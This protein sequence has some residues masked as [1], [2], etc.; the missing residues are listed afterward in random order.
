MASAFRKYKTSFSMEWV[1][2]YDFV[3]QCSVSAPDYQH[4]FRCNICSINLSCSAVGI[5]DVKKH[6]EAPTHQKL[7]NK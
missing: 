6:S 2:T 7:I 5:N 1:N 3:S 4:K